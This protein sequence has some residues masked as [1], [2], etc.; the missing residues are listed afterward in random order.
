MQYDD[1]FLGA[2]ALQLLL[3]EGDM[4]Y[5][6][7][8]WIHYIVSLT[9]TVQCNGRFVNAPA[10]IADPIRVTPGAGGNTGGGG[11]G[12]NAQGGDGRGTN[13]A[14]SL[15]YAR[16]GGYRDVLRCHLNAGEH[17]VSSAMGGR[18]QEKPQFA[19]ENV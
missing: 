19:M 17:S 6:P 15:A 9:P 7:S 3:V 8:Y 14:A 16:H 5:L 10:D 2:E 12:G 13:D 11:G 1:S 4:L 18:H